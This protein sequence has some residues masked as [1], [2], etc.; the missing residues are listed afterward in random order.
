MIDG[1]GGGQSYGEQDITFSVMSLHC[2]WVT[3]LIALRTYK[4]TVWEVDGAYIYV[5][6]NFWK[7]SLSGRQFG[8]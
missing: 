5:C 6:F 4:S 7:Q 2:M 1:K 8:R 3:L